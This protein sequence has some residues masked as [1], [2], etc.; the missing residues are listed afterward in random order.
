MECLIADCTDFKLIYCRVYSDES[1][2]SGGKL[3]MTHIEDFRG[4]E[5][6]LKSAQSAAKFQTGRAGPP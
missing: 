4:Y 6:S 2:Q 5:I 1:T 3:R